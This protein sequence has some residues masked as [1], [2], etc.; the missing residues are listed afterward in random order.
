MKTLNAE[1]IDYIIENT[2]YGDDSVYTLLNYASNPETIQ[3]LMDKGLNFK[4]IKIWHLLTS[5]HNITQPV[6]NNVNLPF[7]FERC[8][9]P[10][11]KYYLLFLN[12]ELSSD[13]LKMVIHKNNIN[14]L[15]D[16]IE[17][18]ILDTDF[19]T[20]NIIHIIDILDLPVIETL[21][22]LKNKGVRLYLDLECINSPFLNKVNQHYQHDKALIDFMLG[23]EFNFY[24]Y[25]QNIIDLNT[26]YK[27]VDPTIKNNVNAWIDSA[28]SVSYDNII[29]DSIS[30]NQKE[31]LIKTLI[32][33]SELIKYDKNSKSQEQILDLI[34]QVPS[35]LINL[36]DKEGKNILFIME[37]EHRFDLLESILNS[38]HKKGLDFSKENINGVNHM[39]LFTHYMYSTVDNETWSE[40]II[41][42]INFF[43]KEKENIPNEMMTFIDNQF[44]KLNLVRDKESNVF[45]RCVVDH[46]KNK[47]SSI[48]EI[49]ADPKK[50]NRI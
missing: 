31:I 20:S 38:L 14:I 30:N 23:N 17:P 12:K 2:P 49:N 21:N 36:E 33:Y 6:I 25:E 22:H 13:V 43:Y 5:D 24:L 42:T 19:Q 32:S 28:V 18:G 8:F 48:T 29:K 11:D 35:E 9:S 7:L 10:Q 50:I 46:I 47:L 4:N 26:L 1:L 16:I 34:D 15:E 27:R 3:K 45:T 41:N 44:Q 37:Y 40:F 39:V